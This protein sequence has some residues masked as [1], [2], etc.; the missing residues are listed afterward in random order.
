M[1]MPDE[2]LVVVDMQ[3]VFADPASPWY[4]PSFAQTASSIAAL[5]PHFAGRTIFT[6]FVPPVQVGG[7]WLPYYSKW[8]FATAAGRDDAMWSLVS[9]WEDQPSIDS[10][11]F[12]KS[13]PA[14]YDITGPHPRL[15]ICGVSTDCCVLGTALAAVDAGAHVRVI[16]DACGAKTPEIQRQSL[17][18]L[19]ARAPMLTLSTGAGL[20]NVTA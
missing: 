17:Q 14:L 8:N 18:L 3:T 15:A 9:P 6:R 4:L 2:F 12:S 5:L 19:A 7:S 13:V 10:H 16:T 20:I 11:Q 1:A